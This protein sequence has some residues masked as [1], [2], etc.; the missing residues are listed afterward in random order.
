MGVSARKC[1][2]ILGVTHTAIFK[3]A[4]QG[5]IPREADGTFD[6]EKV[7]IAWE[8]NTI[9]VRNPQSLAKKAATSSA[10]ARTPVSDEPQTT[11]QPQTDGNATAYNP[12][13]EQSTAEA[14]R[15]QAWI[16]VQREQLELHQKSGEYVQVAEV[17]AAVAG[18]IT[19]ARTRFLVIGAELRD[20]L[21]QTSDPI[22]CGVMV[23][24]KIAEALAELAGYRPA[25]ETTEAIAA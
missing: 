14:Q 23:D 20:K 13:P 10:T 19:A 16:R 24:K 1:G 15:Q 2:E 7:R 22:E 11:T 25:A 3:A 6:P 4:K 9:T 8:A 21:A 5:R 18:M 17:R 12:P